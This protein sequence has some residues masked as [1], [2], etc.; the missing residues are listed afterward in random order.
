MG[1][2]FYLSSWLVGVLAQNHWR[3]PSRSRDSQKDLVE[4][5]GEGL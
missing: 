4:N 2:D 5:F 1:H 3:S